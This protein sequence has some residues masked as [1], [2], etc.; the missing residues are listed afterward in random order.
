MRTTRWQ[1][2]A[3]LVGL[4]LVCSGCITA[5]PSITAED[6]GSNV[7]EDVSTNSQ[8]G[9][10]SVQASVT[11][12]QS[13]TTSR[14]VTQLNV[15]TEDGSSF[16]STT[17][18]SGQTSVSVPVPTDGSSRIFAVNTVNG[19]VVSTRNLTVTGTTYP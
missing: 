8:W 11:L 9:T 10:S 7:F 13:A 2:K 19:T 18:D 15:I 4:L 14:G 5:Q 16:Y 12:T 1:L 17:V 3:A 6:S